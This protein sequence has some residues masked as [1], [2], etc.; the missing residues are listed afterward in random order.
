MSS[1]LTRTRGKLPLPMKLDHELRCTAC[2]GD[3]T[4][5][6]IAEHSPLV[7]PEERLCLR[8]YGVR[9]QAVKR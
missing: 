3:A 9:R 7:R 4:A 1:Y 5:G 6:Y 2:R 8:C